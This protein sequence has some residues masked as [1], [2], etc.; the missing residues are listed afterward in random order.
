MF[1][2]NSHP[3]SSSNAPAA[4]EF[5]EDVEDLLAENLVSAQRTAKLLDKASKA[6]IRGINRRIRKTSGRNQARDAF[7]SKL[8][9]RKWLDYYVFRCR[10]WDRKAQQEVAVEIHR[11]ALHTIFLHMYFFVFIL[12]QARQSPH[13]VA[14]LSKICLILS[15]GS[16]ELARTRY[17]LR[18][19]GRGQGQGQGLAKKAA[20]G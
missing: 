1:S 6:G 9:W 3:A 18:G 13:T 19:R 15:H 17:H 14:A 12:A 16:I 10:L 20:D 5:Q 8:K 4:Q 11:T 7:R 2:R